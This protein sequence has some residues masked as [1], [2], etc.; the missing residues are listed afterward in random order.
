MRLR[1]RLHAR[2]FKDSSSCSCVDGCNKQNQLFSMRNDETFS[3][4]HHYLSMR[5]IFR[6]CLLVLLAIGIVFG[7]DE[8]PASTSEADPEATPEA[9]EAT[10]V[11]AATAGED[12]A[13]TGEGIL[14]ALA[15]E[16]GTEARY[17]KGFMKK[18]VTYS[19]DTLAQLPEG[20]EESLASL[21]MVYEYLN[22]DS[23]SNRDEFQS[24]PPP[25]WKTVRYHIDGIFWRLQSTLIPELTKVT[26][27]M[28]PFRPFFPPSHP[29]ETTLEYERRKHF[30]GVGYFHTVC[31]AVEKNRPEYAADPDIAV[32]IV[33][34]ELPRLRAL[35]QII[36]FIARPIHSLSSNIPHDELYRPATRFSEDQP[37]IDIAQVEACIHA[38]GGWDIARSVVEAVTPVI[39]TNDVN[40]SRRN[41]E[42]ESLEEDSTSS[43]DSLWGEEDDD[44]DKYYKEICSVVEGE[45]QTEESISVVPL[46]DS[47]AYSS[48]SSPI[49]SSSTSSLS[50]SE[51]GLAKSMKSLSAIDSK[52]EKVTEAIS[53]EKITQ[54]KL[55]KLRTFTAKAHKKNDETNV[56]VK[57]PA[58]HTKSQIVD[59]KVSKHMPLVDVKPFEKKHNLIMNEAFD[60]FD[61]LRPFTGDVGAI[62]ANDVQK[63]LSQFGPAVERCNSNKLSRLMKKFFEPDEKG[64]RSHR[65]AYCNTSV[66]GA[67]S[68]CQHLS[69]LRHIRAKAY[70]WWM[71]L[72]D[73]CAHESETKIKQKDLADIWSSLFAS[74]SGM[75][76]LFPKCNTSIPDWSSAR[77]HIGLVLTKL[78]KWHIP[79][80]AKV[81]N[82][83]LPFRPFD[84]YFCQGESSDEY[85]RRK[86]FISVGYCLTVCDAIEK[87]RPD[88]AP[89][90]EEA[91]AIVNR[92]MPRMRIL[93]DII[94][95]IVRPHYLP[96][97]LSLR[98]SQFHLNPQIRNGESEI[99]LDQFI[100][101]IAALGG[102]KN[103]RS[104]VA[105]YKTAK[106]DSERK[107]IAAITA[108]IAL[109]N[110]KIDALDPCSDSA[111]A[112]S[113]SPPLSAHSSTEDILPEKQENIPEN[114]QDCERN[115]DVSENVDNIGEIINKHEFDPFDI[116]RPFG[117]EDGPILENAPSLLLK[118]RHAIE[119]CNKK[120]LG[121]LTKHLF[122]CEENGGL[123]K[124]CG[125][126][127][128]WVGGAVM[129]CYHISS[130]YHMKQA[131]KSL[132]SARS[133]SWW[134]NI[135]K[136]CTDQAL[137][138]AF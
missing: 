34:R 4:C 43:A 101:T 25:N 18:I 136:S 68:M 118:C 10:P 30:V 26:N 63:L 51:E 102:W 50:S 54:K 41:S 61:I 12:T 79:K 125:Y 57:K 130:N 3:S 133:Y 44:F 113:P 42:S 39:P 7:E 110:T 36:Q 59:I 75:D 111:Y 106:S 1:T 99:D 37:L 94:Q 73:A 29:D 116:L 23:D 17:L 126:C 123:G 134:M 47:S 69:S 89:N 45:Q 90:P 120:K 53:T 98:P 77:E 15:F 20:A 80:L 83:L 121:R 115:T 128:M 8:L 16:L 138:L 103:A 88:F 60:P 28:I 11:D 104:I 92:E 107:D 132:V 93:L 24:L 14:N 76:L 56:K 78:Q 109:E 27:T 32:E 46:S 84:P 74:P 114:P 119:R 48:C 21:N 22:S 13:I 72:I 67:V 9:I 124:W 70:N 52:E 127:N 6:I 40:E 87:N 64:Q 2:D 112:S 129:L 95:A 33:H 55:E 58:T 137:G 31:D 108:S 86:Y 62:A 5:M 91:I 131:G 105:E 135:V 100:E 81:T 82:T 71:E 85:E 49:L 96:P 38:L 19:M 122:S 35:L 65:C 117:R 66:S 97:Y